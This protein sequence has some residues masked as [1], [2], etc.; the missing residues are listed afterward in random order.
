[1]TTNDD[2]FLNTS[3]ILLKHKIDEHTYEKFLGIANAPRDGRATFNVKAYI[4]K[5]IRESFMLQKGQ[6]WEATYLGSIV[7]HSRMFFACKSLA[8]READSCLTKVFTST[9]QVPSVPPIISSLMCHTV[10]LRY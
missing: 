6:R 3:V 2:Q 9:I 10:N 4:R 5:D 7:T 8:E 1:M